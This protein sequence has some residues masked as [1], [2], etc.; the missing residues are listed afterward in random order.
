MLKN[1]LKDLNLNLDLNLNNKDNK[2]K[3]LENNNLS[4]NNDKLDDFWRVKDVIDLNEKQSL[5]KQEE[6][7]KYT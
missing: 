5:R 7:E 1:F 3:D 6:I 2:N 4:E